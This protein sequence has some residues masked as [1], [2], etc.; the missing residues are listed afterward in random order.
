M[1]APLYAR[2]CTPCTRISTMPVPPRVSLVAM[3]IASSPS[4]RGHKRGRLEGAEAFGGLYS[5]LIAVSRMQYGL[6][7]PART[8]CHLLS[9]SSV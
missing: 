5:L 9:G 6:G 1:E 8:P 2:Y 7:P 4:L 3:L